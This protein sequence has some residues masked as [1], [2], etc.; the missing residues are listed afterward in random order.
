[1]AYQYPLELT[2]KLWSLTP[3]FS[4]TD[5]QGNSLFYVRQQMF[6]LKEVINIFTDDRRTQELYTIRADRVIDFSA[7][8]HFDNASGQT[9]GAVKRKGMKSIWKAHYE[10]YD[11][12]NQLSFHVQEQNPWVKVMDALFSEIPVVGMFTGLV[13][14][15]VYEVTRADGTLV[16]RLEK[17][18]T[19]LSRK[20]TIKQL[21]QMTGQEEAQALLSLL[22]L[23]L[24]ERNRG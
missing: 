21:N 13:F 6:R 23:L 22:M 12:H 3:Q 18:P 2:F 4:L 5:Q 14:N 8:Y 11:A 24:L 15:P 16:M 9:I 17:I 19:F 7:Q 20:F 10:V 1:M